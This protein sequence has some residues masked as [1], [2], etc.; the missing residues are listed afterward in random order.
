MPLGTLQR[1][2]L[3]SYICPFY[4]GYRPDL[5]TILDNNPE[6]GFSLSTYSTYSTYTSISAS[7]VLVARRRSAKISA[8]L[9]SKAKAISLC[10]RCKRRKA[11]SLRW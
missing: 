4:G 2:H 11:S 10:W 1:Y 8:T 3:H 5:L 6:M 7:M 9:L